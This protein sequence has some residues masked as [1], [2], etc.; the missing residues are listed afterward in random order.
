MKR[1][2]V[3]LLAIAATA[4]VYAEKRQRN[5]NQDAAEH[6]C[7]KSCRHESGR[8][9][10]HECHNRCRNAAHD[11]VVDGVAGAVRDAVTLGS[12]GIIPASVDAERGELGH[13]MRKSAR[14]LVGDVVT[15]GT[16]GFVN[17][18]SNERNEE[19]NK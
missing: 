11:F 17:G 9:A 14:G 7:H 6:A 3:A 15:V 5:E 1:I 4:Q 12:V 13:N 8:E 19:N 18:N 16:L 2:L 10:R